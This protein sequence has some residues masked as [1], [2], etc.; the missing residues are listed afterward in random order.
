MDPSALR[1]LLLARTTEA[2]ACPLP[3]ERPLV[4]AVLARLRD[5]STWRAVVLDG[6]RQ[7]GKSTALYQVLRH[8]R[9]HP[10]GAATYCNFTDPRLRGTTLLDVVQAVGVEPGREAAT[11]FLLDEVHHVPDWSREL[12]ELVDRRAARFAVADSS[13]TVIHAAGVEGGLGRWDRIAAHPL[14]FSEWLALQEAEGR[15]APRAEPEVQ[16]ECRRY[17]LLGG[18]PEHAFAPSLARVH[19]RLRSDVGIQAVRH[20]IAPLRG[21]RE[22]ESLERLLVA[23]LAGS[24]RQ[25]NLS[26]AAELASTSRQTARHWVTALE[27]TALLWSLPHLPSTDGAREKKAP[28]LYAA[29]PGLVGAFSF[30]GTLDQQ[31]QL[32]GRQVE[33]SVAQALRRRAERA[34]GQ[35]A[36]FRDRRGEIDF[37]LVERGRRVLLEA[38][39]GDGRDK[40]GALLRYGPRLR[41]DE[42]VVVAAAR[43]QGEEVEADPERVK[44]V[45]LHAF[46][47]DDQGGLP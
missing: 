10:G 30:A 38:T 47:L 26:E 7:V 5:A 39:A 11:W 36:W 45:P 14:S 4:D 34:G 35:L 21:I 42:L 22:V 27:E 9:G 15:R 2:A 1:T 17:L 41:A 37:V 40:V 18:F 25:L 31:A 6:P 3:Y 29:D 28:K 46:Q 23:C 13:A 44:L 32:V 12:K 20:D 43:Q 33:T 24:G 8:L 16:E 19:E